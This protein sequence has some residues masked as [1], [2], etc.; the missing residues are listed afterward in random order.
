MIVYPMCNK[1]HVYNFIL[2]V[3]NYEWN[4]IFSKMEMMKFTMIKI[5]VGFMTILSTI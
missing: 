3:E 5:A 2:G 4:R 1:F